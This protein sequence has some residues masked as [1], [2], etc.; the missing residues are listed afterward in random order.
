[1]SNFERIKTMDAEQLAKFLC[2]N[3][4][5]ERCF[6]SEYCS[7]G[8]NGVLRWLKAGGEND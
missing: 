4:E 8:A 3:M 6:A 7:Y 5:C 2:R 1:M